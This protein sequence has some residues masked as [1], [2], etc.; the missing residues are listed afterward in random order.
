MEN[1]GDG[2]VRIRNA[3]PSNDYIHIENLKGYAQH[4]MMY[5]VWQSAQWQLEQVPANALAR[6]GSTPALSISNPNNGQKLLPST[7]NI[8][9]EVYPNP[10]VSELKLQS[11]YDL[12]GGIIYILNSSGN[13]VMR[14]NAAARTV[15]IA[16]LPPGVYTLLFTQK[17]QKITKRFVKVQ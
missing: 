3:G 6:S 10:A 14:S 1:T 4:G 2:Y 8:T 9:L 5:P 12:L 15:N 17:T 7:E 11:K 13:I 16:A